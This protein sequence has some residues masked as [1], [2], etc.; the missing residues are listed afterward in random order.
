MLG[1]TGLRCNIED[2]GESQSG[3][4][5][6]AHDVTDCV[7]HLALQQVIHRNPGIAKIAKNV[8]DARPYRRRQHGFIRLCCR[9]DHCLVNAL[10]EREHR[11]V[12]AL[13]RILWISGTRTAGDQHQHA[14]NYPVAST[15]TQA[16]K[17]GIQH[18]PLWRFVPTHC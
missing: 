5:Q 12:V 2:A 7:G 18:Q 9:P 13:E 15:R 14:C 6:E 8:T 1:Q 16:I 10:V 3:I 17:S 4:D 11:P